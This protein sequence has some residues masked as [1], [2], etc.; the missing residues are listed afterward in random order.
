MEYGK[1]VDLCYGF[2]ADGEKKES[3]VL[4]NHEFTGM[5]PIETSP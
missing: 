2:E 1:G 4:I 5:K 3:T